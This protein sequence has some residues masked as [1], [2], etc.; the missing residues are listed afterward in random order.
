MATDNWCGR[1]LFWKSR[2]WGNL[3]IKL[4]NIYMSIKRLFWSFGHFCPW[5]TVI[6]RTWSEHRNTWLTRGS[7]IGLAGCGIWLFFVVILRMRAQNGSGKREFWWRA[8]AGFPIFMSL[9]CGKRRGKVAGN[10]NL[11][12]SWPRRVD[13]QKWLFCMCAVRL[14]G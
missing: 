2:F 10:G 3:R 8:G 14:W 11:V 13:W 9:G 1:V 5:I 7:T 4:P 12:L 6:T